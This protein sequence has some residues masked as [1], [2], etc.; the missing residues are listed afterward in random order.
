[1]EPVANLAGD[2]RAKRQRPS[3]HRINEANLS[4][5]LS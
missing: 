4:R 1:M 2:Q 5:V 3:T